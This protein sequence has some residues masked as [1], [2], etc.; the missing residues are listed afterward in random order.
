M[1]PQ[2]RC[3]E[4]ALAVVGKSYHNIGTIT[5][6]IL[7]LTSNKE[8]LEE[9]TLQEILDFYDVLTNETKRRNV[10]HRMYELVYNHCDTRKVKST[11]MRNA[12]KVAQRN[13]SFVIKKIELN[14]AQIADMVNNLYNEDAHLTIVSKTNKNT[15]SRRTRSEGSKTKRSKETAERKSPKPPYQWQYCERLPERPDS[16]DFLSEAEKQSVLRTFVQ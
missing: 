11:A 9:D 2:V 10:M 12:V 16:G 13:N 15:N 5:K 6:Y 3:N 7:K 4:G 8:R 1:G 14:A